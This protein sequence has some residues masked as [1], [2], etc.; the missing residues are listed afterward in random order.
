MGKEKKDKGVGDPIKI[1]LEG[2]LKKQ[3]NVMVDKFAQILQ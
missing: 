3:R 2:A 1:L